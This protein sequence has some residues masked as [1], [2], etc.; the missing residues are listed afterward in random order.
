ML[1]PPF[2]A[3]G[4][5]CSGHSSTAREE[6]VNSRKQFPAISEPY[7]ISSV[8]MWPHDQCGNPFYVP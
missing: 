8:V 6:M 1:N 5:T 2:R 4:Q 3:L 7:L